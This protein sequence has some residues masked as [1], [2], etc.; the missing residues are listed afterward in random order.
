[1]TFLGG[2]SASSSD[3]GS[4]VPSIAADAVSGMGLVHLPDGNRVAALAHR[5]DEAA[6]E[7]L[8]SAALPV[9]PSIRAEAVNEAS[10]VDG[11]RGALP[12][13][14]RIDAEAAGRDDPSD[15]SVDSSFEAE[16]VQLQDPP[17]NR[18]KVYTVSS[19]GAF[20]VGLDNES[21]E[22]MNLITENFEN[23]KELLREHLELELD[24]EFKVSI[25]PRSQT[26]CYEI[27]R[28]SEDGEEEV[29]EAGALDLAELIRNW[30]NRAN[31]DDHNKATNLRNYIEGIQKGLSRTKALGA[32]IGPSSEGMLMLNFGGFFKGESIF[33]TINQAKREHLLKSDSPTTFRDRYFSKIEEAIGEGFDG[34]E[35]LQRLAKVTRL[36]RELEI[37][38]HEQHKAKVNKLAAEGKT[39]TPEDRADLEQD[40]R[41]LK[42]HI[43]AFSGED[44]RGGLGRFF[45]GPLFKGVDSF[46]L[47]LASSL[48]GQQEDE[49]PQECA[50]RIKEQAFHV[51]Q[52][53]SKEIK[54]KTYVRSKFR[55]NKEENR[56]YATLV[57]SLFLDNRAEREQFL[58]QNFPGPNNV[59][60]K[61]FGYT[62]KLLEMTAENANATKVFDKMLTGFSGDM[63]GVL[64]SEFAKTLRKVNPPPD[65][66]AAAG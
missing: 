26:A 20:E 49:S 54:N 10:E 57:A 28:K 13:G 41:E 39:M 17:A 40:I 64:N 43:R 4:S 60:Q 5:T 1:M 8:E 23:A 51:L 61:T 18:V 65:N 6:R 37:M 9:G 38:F 25:R 47:Y 12:N 48:P 15:S 50:V 66:S 34:R 31:G 33:T 44:P 11:G 56:D 59:L 7:A 45:R 53:R 55:M 30:S 46:M 35:T 36:K 2:L 52:A 29:I 16:G 58:L 14:L 22:A 62:Q 27:V 63:Q 24:H 21:E 3:S 19:I 42:R 32:V